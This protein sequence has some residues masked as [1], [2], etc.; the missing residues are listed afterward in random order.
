MRVTTL[1]VAFQDTH[2]RKDTHSG[3][4]HNIASDT[5]RLPHAAYKRYVVF[6]LDALR[7]TYLLDF[8]SRSDKPLFHSYSGQFPS[9]SLLFAIG[10]QVRT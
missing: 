10:I 4:L 2:C 5:T 6:W 9:L 3:L 8:P 1:W 7:S